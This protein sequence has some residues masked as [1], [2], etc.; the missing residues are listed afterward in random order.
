MR[1]NRSCT[2]LANFSLWWPSFRTSTEKAVQHNYTAS[3]LF[4]LYWFEWKTASRKISWLFMGSRLIWWTPA[5]NSLQ[6][7]FNALLMLF[8]LLNSQL[9]KWSKDQEMHV[10]ASLT[11]SRVCKEHSK[12]NKG[13]KRIGRSYVELR[14]HKSKLDGFLQSILL[15]QS[16]CW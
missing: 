9:G 5:T 3:E 4:N 15:A 2:N 16:N 8:R 7:D 10:T 13:Q 6:M 12:C 14:R 1:G 11:M